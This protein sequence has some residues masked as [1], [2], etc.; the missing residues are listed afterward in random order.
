MPV[1]FSSYLAQT[2]TVFEKT[3]KAG[4]DAPINEAIDKI[5]TALGQSKALLVC[6]NGGS[7]ADAMHISGEL[8][9]RFLLERPALKVIALPAN[10]VSLTAW[11]NDYSYETVFSRQTEGYGEKGGVLW[12]IS[13]SGNS[14][15]IIAA[16]QQA[17]SMGM[18]TIGLTGEA[19][20]KMAPLCDILIAVP[21][22]IT[23]R[24][25]EAP[26]CI[27]PY[28]CEEVEKRLKSLT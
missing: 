18:T 2:I 26:I 9:G 23:P 15:N 12:G 11:A 8:V 7:A 6:G 3:I 20:G 27:S 16:L 19:G 21:S 24:S 4:L 17:R 25:Q 14:P 5:S 10:T 22:K 1:N 13:T 28:I